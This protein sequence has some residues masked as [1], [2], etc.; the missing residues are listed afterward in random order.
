MLHPVRLGIDILIGPNLHAVT[1]LQHG[2]YR[3][4]SAI[5]A[6]ILCMLSHFAMNFVGK[7]ECSSIFRKNDG[8]PFRGKHHNIII[9]ERR[10]HTLHKINVIA[11]MSHIFEYLTELFEPSF[12][13]LFRALGRAS[14]T[15]ISQHAF[16]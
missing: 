10:S 3:R 8:F 1:T 9:V 16:R 5:Y 2:F 11:M 6:G 15:R 14:K 12:D 4:Q 13:I 7:I